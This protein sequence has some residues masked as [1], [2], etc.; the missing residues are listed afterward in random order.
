MPSRSADGF[1]GE[2]EVALFAAELE[3]CPQRNN[4]TCW[5]SNTDRIAHQLR[6]CA[7]TFTR[8]PLNATEPTSGLNDRRR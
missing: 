6:D 5:R 3:V 7:A 4:S 2:A 1:P 8:A